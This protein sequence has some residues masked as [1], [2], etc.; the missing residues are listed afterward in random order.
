VAS[1]ALR[2]LGP[3]GGQRVLALAGDFTQEARRLLTAAGVEPL[4]LGDFGWTD[5][6]YKAIRDH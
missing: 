3:V 5:E 1:A 4:G 6:S 2:R